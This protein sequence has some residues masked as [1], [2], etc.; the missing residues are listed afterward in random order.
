M[1][2]KQQSLLRLMIT[3]RRNQ[4]T[5]MRILIFVACAVTLT[6]VIGCLGPKRVEGKTVEQPAIDRQTGAVLEATTAFLNSLTADQRQKVQFAFLPQKAGTSANFHRTAD[7]SVAPGAPAGG[8]RSGPGG[9]PGRGPTGRDG[10]PA[11]PRA[12]TRGLGRPPGGPGGGAGMGP[13]GGFIG[14]QYGQAVW[15]NY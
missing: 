8:Q 7:G 15:S 9:G 14:E 13:P 1:R 12:Q 3:T 11:G 10:G 6:G 4:R 2:I 5:E